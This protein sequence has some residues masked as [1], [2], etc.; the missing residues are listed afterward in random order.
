MHAARR[1]VAFAADVENIRPAKKPASAQAPLSASSACAGRAPADAAPGRVALAP[2]ATANSLNSMGALGAHSCAAS[3]TRESVPATPAASEDSH[4]R[5][6]VRIRPPFADEVSN[7]AYED[8]LHASGAVRDEGRELAG[9]TLHYA[10][11]DREFAYDGVFGP[12]ASQADVFGR[13]AQAIVDRFV[14]GENGC[15]LAY[16]QTGTGK[17]Y[18][19]GMLDQAVTDALALDAHPDTGIVPRALVRIFELL[20]E[21]PCELTLSFVQMYCHQVQDLLA[22]GPG[23]ALEIREDPETGFYARNLTRRAVTSVEQA[24]AC[25]QAG[26]GNRVM[27]ST[28]MNATSSRSHVILIVDLLREEPASFV[29]SKLM[30]VDLAGSERVKK[31]TSVGARLAE[32]RHI[33][34][35]LSALGNVIAAKTATRR[36]VHVPWRDSKL[37]KL[38]Q[39][40]LDGSAN[41]VLLA[42]VG[43]AASNRDESLS[44]L[45]FAQRC[46][47]V[48]THALVCEVTASA[49]AA[50]ASERAMLALKLRDCESA[51]DALRGENA[52]LKAHVPPSASASASA[53]ATALLTGPRLFPVTTGPVWSAASGQA[54]P[55]GAFCGE[56]LQALYDRSVDVVATLAGDQAAPSAVRL[57]ENGAALQA[58]RDEGALA[59]YLK[60]LVASIEAN[61]DCVVL[62]L[63]E[64][65]RAMDD[66]RQQHAAELASWTMILRHLLEENAELRKG[67]ES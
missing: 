39:R 67:Q 2:I 19:L 18:T 1:T 64:R 23:A 31:T 34:Q 16:G 32:A 6:F 54:T 20:G 35:S 52:R 63:E 37:T 66:L 51:M 59:D 57:S 30:L 26:L 21:R 41:T 28:S 45:Q 56:L 29:A 36:P 48:R 13:A 33:N 58:L 38:L 44:T 60:Q 25:V 4:V 10:D 46:M 47:H 15:V 14:A 27:A 24:L 9:L 17:T 5:A 62:G 50:A 8:V 61:W 42:T 12:Q 40:C 65:E 43:P 55:L 22:A 7:G 49:P 53:R 3:A 11:Y